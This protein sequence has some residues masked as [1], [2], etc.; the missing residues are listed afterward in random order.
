MYLCDLNPFI[1]FAGQIFYKS[2]YNPVFVRDARLFYILSGNADIFIENKHYSLIPNSVFYCVAGSRYNIIS[3]SGISLLSLNF[4]L[5]QSENQNFLVNVPISAAELDTVKQNPPSV[6]NSGFLNTHLL[7]MNGAEFLP[8]LKK[9]CDEFSLQKKYFREK[10]SA[11]LKEVLIDLHR[12]QLYNSGNASE[13]VKAVIDFIHNHFYED[14]DNKDLAALS[15]YHE[16]HLNRIFF[17]YTGMSMHKYILNLRIN[18]A[19]R[20]VLNTNLP[21]GQI[22]EKVGFC[23]G[24]YFSSY[25]KKVTGF[26]PSQF[27]SAF[28][29][30]I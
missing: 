27:R 25:F 28:K 14:I 2:S 29:N 1:R 24:T 22:S 7:Q 15:G 20:L 6:L 13:S 21:V 10:C 23:N 11:L 8:P 4:D 30:N 26:S 16:F 19:K 18:E 3:D 5:T 17:K 9:I 12:G